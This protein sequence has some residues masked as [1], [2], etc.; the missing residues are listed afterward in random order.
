M[1]EITPTEWMGYAASLGVLSSFFMKEMTTLRIVNI[2]GCSF[3]IIYG[4]MMPSL[5]IAL[6]II[7]TNVAIVLVNTYYLLLTVRKKKTTQ[8]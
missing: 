3:F 4:L 7:I 1:F 2:I 8:K 5:R 6:P